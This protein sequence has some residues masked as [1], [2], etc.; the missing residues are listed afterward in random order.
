MLTKDCEV[1]QPVD[2][3]V[4]EDLQKLFTLFCSGLRFE[5]Q[6]VKAAAVGGS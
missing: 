4:G 5:V 1:V 3:V 2:M 6:T